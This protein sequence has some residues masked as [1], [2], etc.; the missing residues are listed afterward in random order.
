V[1]QS[2]GADGVALLHERDAARAEDLVE[3]LNGVK[4]R[5]GERLIDEIP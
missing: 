5:V 2:T 1:E 4:V 3:V